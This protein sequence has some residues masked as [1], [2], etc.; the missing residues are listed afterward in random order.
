LEMLESSPDVTAGI[1]SSLSVMDR[2]TQRLARGIEDLLM[3]AKVGDPHPPVSS[4]AVDL[5]HVVD[6][7]VEMSSVAADRKGIIVSVQAPDGPL[8]AL[9]DAAELDRVGG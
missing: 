1:R 8:I 6:E 5:H 7:V 9:G 3:L 2:G 4:A